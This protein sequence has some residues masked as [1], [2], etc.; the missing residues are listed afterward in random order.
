M[1]RWERKVL[2]FGI[3]C[4][5]RS[6]ER[7]A[8][9]TFFNVEEDHTDVQRTRMAYHGSQRTIFARPTASIPGRLL[10]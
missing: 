8:C 9:P 7:K 2:I 4:Q 1:L 3:H 10:S 6:I 5:D